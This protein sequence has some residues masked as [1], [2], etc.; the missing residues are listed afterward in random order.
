MK[1]LIIFLFVITITT[2]AESFLQETQFYKHPHLNFHFEAA[3]NWINV[4]HPEDKLIYEMISPDSVLHVMLWYTE[5]EQSA[6]KY[7]IKM[8]DMKGLDLD[9]NKPSTEKIDGK[10][11]WLLRSP[12]NIGRIHA[13]S[14]ISV[15]ADGKVSQRP[16]ENKL[17]IVQIWC[18]EESFP[19]VNNN[20]DEIL[21]SIKIN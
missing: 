7:L 21:G 19:D 10:D 12:G 5:T 16:K 3:G 6:K 18:K 11:S 8:S 1:Y 14:F 15:T 9:N 4:P 2:P 20:F 17:Y 13:K